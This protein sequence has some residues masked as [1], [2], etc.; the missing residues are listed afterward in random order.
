MTALARR[1]AQAR[2][3]KTLARKDSKKRPWKT[4]AARS[5]ASTADLSQARQQT[6]A[7]AIPGRGGPSLAAP[8]AS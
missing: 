6:M 2:R 1:S 3:Q 4:T 7:K 5:S 8:Q